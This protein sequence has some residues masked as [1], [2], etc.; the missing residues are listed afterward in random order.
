M[1]AFGDTGRL[2]PEGK[3]H[4]LIVY[5]EDIHLAKTDKY[6]DL[7]GLEVLRDLLTTREWYSTAHKSNRVIDDTNIMACIDTSAEQI[8]RV[9]SRLLCRFSAVGMEGFDS[10]T[11]V[12]IMK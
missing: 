3:K 5:L 6:G 9:P 8:Q 1:E 2:K 12:H 10:V 4:K 7:P 11:S